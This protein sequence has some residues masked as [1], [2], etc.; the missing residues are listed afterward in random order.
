MK[1]SMERR[2]FGS[3]GKVP[4][5]NRDFHLNAI[6]EHEKSFQY[7]VDSLSDFSFV[8]SSDFMDRTRMHNSFLQDDIYFLL[9]D[10]TTPMAERK[11]LEKLKILANEVME[12]EI[13]PLSGTSIESIPPF[14]KLKALP[15]KL[16]R[17]LEITP[18][19]GCGGSSAWDRSR[20]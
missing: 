5:R 8:V 16:E 1:T 10:D 20:R 18:E 3:R 12:D 9:H 14:P 2:T 19:Y 7:I 11:K 4:V 17:F 15:K 13:A 6:R